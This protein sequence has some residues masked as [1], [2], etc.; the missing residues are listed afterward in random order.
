MKLLMFQARSFE[1][2][3]PATHPAPWEQTDPPTQ[4]SAGDGSGLT[5]VFIHAESHD[6]DR[7]TAL[8]TKAVRNIKWLSNKRGLRRVA[9]HS[10]A[11]LSDSKADP[12]FAGAFIES[13]AQRLQRAGYEV[14]TTPFGSSVGWS[15]SVFEEPIAKVFKTL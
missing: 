1:F 3:A 14:E 11:H 13:I 4:E 6:T 12:A 5:V 7:G 8:E 10:F 9:L 15:L 2:K